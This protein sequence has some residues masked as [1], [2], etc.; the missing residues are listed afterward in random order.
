M[1]FNP[2]KLYE[3]HLGMSRKN[4][5]EKKLDALADYLGVEFAVRDK[6]AICVKDKAYRGKLSKT[7][8][9]SVTINFGKGK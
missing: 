7:D 1:P 3:S 4:V 2:A 8:V 6:Q 9:E 5:I